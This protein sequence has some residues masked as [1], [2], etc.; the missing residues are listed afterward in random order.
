MPELDEWFLALPLRALSDA[1]LSKAKDLGCSHAEVRV[2]R[3]R[4]AYRSFRDHALETT[5][6][7]QVL[8][9]SVRVVHNG[10][11][12]FAADITLSTDSAARLADRAV[13]TAKVSRPLT[14]ASVE[15]ADEDIYAD[16]TWVSAYEVDPF[17]VDEA[18]KTG[19]V[20][21]LNEVLLAAPVVTHANAI[22]G[23][24]HEN[25]YFANLAGTSTTQQRVRIQAQLT[26]VSVGD[27]GFATMRTTAPPTGRG[28]EYLTGTGWDFDAEVAEI[29]EL[30][31]AHVAAPSVNAGLY[32]LVIHPS[33]LFLT[34]HES[35]GHA[36]ELDRALGYEA[37]YAGTSFAT[38]EQ[39]GKLEYG[40][41]AMNVTG[42]RVVDH[43]LATIGYDDE[44]VA[45]QRFD[46]IAGGTLVGYQLNRQMAAEKGFGRSNG[47]AYADSPGHIAMQR[48]PNVS[49]QPASG[50]PSTTELISGVDN[51][52]YIVGD[53]SWSIDM[54]RY[55]FQFTGQQF[56][57]IDKGRLA[58]QLKDVAY[59]ATTTDFWRSMEAVGSPDTYVLGG[60]FNCGKGQPGQIAPVSHG[61][62][63]ALFRK[64]NVLNT[65]AEG[66]Q[67]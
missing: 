5:A 44:G 22:L 9:L 64:V 60:A 43:G 14:P 4:Q 46:V 2:E 13:A 24:I 7:G 59:Q 36:T 15:L 65:Q 54:Q 51:G 50:G 52:I 38:F 48:M 33:N 23:Y 34:I 25:K 6:D 8:G 21:G 58:G 67:Q 26:A 18:T 53:K 20:L 40:S 56:Y 57:K 63:A 28:W 41:E 62:P 10:V 27:H 49:L 30:L 29:P 31:A 45:Q 37:A 16:A 39:L 55:N 12:G 42:D 32:D 1:A 66:G 35:I 17:D 47:C 3:L 61:C 11:W 19:R